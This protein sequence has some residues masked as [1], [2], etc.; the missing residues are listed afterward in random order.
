MHY[1][2]NHNAHS[3]TDD[4]MC[5]IR[6]YELLVLCFLLQYIVMESKNTIMSNK[7]NPMFFNNTFSS[8]EDIEF[9]NNKNDA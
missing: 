1:F 3:S 9:Q 8:V 6:S 5:R 2:V 7:N 4:R